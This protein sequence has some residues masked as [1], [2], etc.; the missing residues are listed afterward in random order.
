M[1]Y[2][3]NVVLWS[4]DQTFAFNIWDINSAKAVI[5]SGT[6][7][8]RQ[9]DVNHLVSQVTGIFTNDKLYQSENILFKIMK[10]SI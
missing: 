10:S 4:N 7:G 2:K 8:I 6:F 3:E 1:S 9:S 5:D